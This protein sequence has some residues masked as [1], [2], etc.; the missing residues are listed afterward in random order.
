[1]NGWVDPN[2]AASISHAGRGME[3][4]STWSRI[5]G[6]K[7]HSVLISERVVGVVSGTV[8][9][10]GIGLVWRLPFQIKGQGF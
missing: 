7:E 3:G 5:S 1:M 6:N 2:S 8:G 10:K 9:G 4:A